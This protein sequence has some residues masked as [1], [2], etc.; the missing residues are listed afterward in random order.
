MAMRIIVV[1]C[2]RAG[3]TLAYQLYLKGHQVTVIDQNASAFDNLPADFQGRLVQGDVLTRNVLERAEIESADSLV[4]VTN[5]DSLNVLLAHIARTEHRVSRVVAGNYDPRQRPLQ[6]AFGL[7]VVSSAGWGVERIE[8]LL[9]DAPLKP[10][11]LD[12][13]AGLAI[14]QLKVPESWSG[15]LL[16][17]LLPND[18]ATAFALTRTARALPV[19][20]SL[21]LETG[22][23]IYLSL[24]SDQVAALQSRLGFRQEDRA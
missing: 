11:F 16:Q 20:G 3:S 17:D 18:R 4:A 10:V 21:S 9:S 23:L 22:D 7:P 12:G 24:N 1:G 6:E 8:E 15:R 19:S 14:Y 13:N 5:S 2:G